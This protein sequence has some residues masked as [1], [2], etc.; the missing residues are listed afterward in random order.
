MLMCDLNT[1]RHL[2]DSFTKGKRDTYLIPR[3]LYSLSLSPAGKWS[4]LKPPESLRDLQIEVP[5]GVVSN[6]VLLKDNLHAPDLYLTVMSIGRILKAGYTVQFAGNSCDI[7]NGED[8]RIVGHKPIAQVE[9]R[10]NPCQHSHA[11][12]QAETVDAI[13][14]LITVYSSSIT[15]W[16]SSCNR[17]FSSFH[18]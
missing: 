5:N 14:A 6:K 8:G 18:L 1:G 11:Q 15:R 9:F 2:E 3:V 17:R 13:R 10:Q 12:S 4:E 16:R 7:K